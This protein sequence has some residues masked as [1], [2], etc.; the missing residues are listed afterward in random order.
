M[1]HKASLITSDEIFVDLTTNKKV[2]NTV[3]DNPLIY[4]MVNGTSDSAPINTSYREELTQ[5]GFKFLSIYVKQ[6]LI[7]LF[8][9]R[10]VT[11]LCVEAHIHI[12]PEAH[13]KGHG[14]E[15]V[16][17]GLEYFRKQGFITVITY[18]P[19]NCFHVLKF[20]KDN[21]FEA[22]GLIP[23]AIRYTNEVVNLYVFKRGL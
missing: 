7:G 18:V 14:K 13:K 17:K 22:C 4:Q 1:K 23:E 16:L 15:A 5:K 6:G 10:E 19:S 12:I 9:Y 3:L 2:I 11:K 21:D 20:M 8:S